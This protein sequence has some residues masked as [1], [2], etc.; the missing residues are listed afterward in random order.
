MHTHAVTCV[1]WGGSDRLYS[2]SRDASI[3][4]WDA[5]DGRCLAR[6]T[7]HAHWVNFLS[8]S[9]E[10]VLRTAAFDH[11]GKHD[12]DMHPADLEEGCPAAEAAMA[13]AKSRYDAALRA[14]TCKC[15]SLD[16][17]VG[18]RLVSASDDFTM[19]L[20][21]PLGAA[22]DGDTPQVH[23]KSIA[24]MTGHVQLVNQACFSPDGGRMVASASFD[25]AIRLWDG[26][27]GAYIAVLRGHVGS[28]Y[29]LA[30]SADSRLLLSGS[31]D[32]TLKV[33]DVKT[34]KLKGDLPG[35]ADEVFTVDWSP[36][37]DKAASGGK[38]K[39]L[40]LWGF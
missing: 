31:K 17:A 19:F 20:W 10:Y 37:S 8:V 18:E 13:A 23:S 32:S 6:L 14:T 30:W 33:W 24:R 27:S 5:K 26:S 39:A 40:K 21:C 16:A 29:Q 12:G 4:V 1:V 34:R 35:H 15:G 3:A 25:K 2:G 7:G 11:R 36:A 28:V 38:D 22:R 9:T